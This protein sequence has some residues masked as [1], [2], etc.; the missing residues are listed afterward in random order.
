[1]MTPTASLNPTEI[2]LGIMN[3]HQMIQLKDETEVVILKAPQQFTL[4]SGH[5]NRN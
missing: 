2:L 5:D 3:T 1:M 4:E